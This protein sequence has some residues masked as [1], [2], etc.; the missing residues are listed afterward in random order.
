MGDLYA[1]V[2]K[3]VEVTDKFWL[4]ARNKG[5][6]SDKIVANAGYKN[7]QEVYG[8]AEVLKEKRKMKLTVN[9]RIKR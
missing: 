4:G 9:N 5:Y 3:D 1:E 8:H 7:N 2:G 6:K